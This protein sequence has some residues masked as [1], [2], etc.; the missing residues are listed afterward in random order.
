MTRLAARGSALIYILIAIALIAALTAA[1]MQ[2]ASQ[3]TRS[4]NSFKVSAEINSQAQM[5]RSAIQDCILLYPEGDGS[6]GKF[7]LE[8]DTAYLASPVANKQAANI[9]CPGNNPGAPNQNNHAPIFGGNTGRF[10]PA[11]PALFSPWIYRNTRGSAVAIDGENANGI[12]IRLDTSASD[13][14]LAEA[15]QKVES[16]FTACEA[17]YIVGTGSNGCPN[18]SK[19]LRIWINRTAPTCP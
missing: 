18:G 1:L 19:C 14:Y 7:P 11:T 16:T 3:Q 6:Y 9:R 4:Q 17:D 13:A 10:M 15:M 5:I 2:P 8:P 12:F